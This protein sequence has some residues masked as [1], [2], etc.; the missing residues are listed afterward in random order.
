PGNRH[1]YPFICSAPR[2]SDYIIPPGPGTEQGQVLPFQKK[3]AIFSS[4]IKRLIG[5][6]EFNPAVLPIEKKFRNKGVA[7]FGLALFEVLEKLGSFPE[8]HRTAVVGV[9]QAEVPKLRPL[10]DIGHTRRGNLQEDLGKGVKPK[11]PGKSDYK[12]GLSY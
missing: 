8:I 3:I 6:I 7:A 9:N 4:K 11:F 5:D 10:V 12:M 2:K 1:K